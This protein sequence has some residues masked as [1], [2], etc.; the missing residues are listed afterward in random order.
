MRTLP[1]LTDMAYELNPDGSYTKTAYNS[2]YIMLRSWIDSFINE[3]SY[4]SYATIPKIVIPNEFIGKPSNPSLNIHTYYAIMSLFIQLEAEPKNSSGYT[5]RLQDMNFNKINSY[6]D[7]SKSLE[8]YNEETEEFFSRAEYWNVRGHLFDL[9][10]NVNKG[11]FLSRHER[12]VDDLC[13]FLDRENGKYI[14][15]TYTAIAPETDNEGNI[16]T[17]PVSKSQI[18]WDNYQPDTRDRTNTDL[19]WK[20][21]T[22]L[23]II[24]K[25]VQDLYY[26]LIKIVYDY[27]RLYESITPYMSQGE[28]YISAITKTSIDNSDKSLSEIHKEI[29]SSGAT[30]ELPN[31]SGFSRYSDMIP[32]TYNFFTKALER[33]DASKYKND[34]DN[35]VYLR[36]F[37]QHEV[38][39]SVDFFNE[40]VKMRDKV[41]EFRS[42]L[43]I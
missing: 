27:L 22:T 33:R 43:D 39:K 38:L 21:N 3:S 41:K 37:Y 42:R 24:R 15:A 36:K 4:P 32:I 8:D 23:E 7:S 40:A 5:E 25:D 34:D 10:T 29:Q 9:L 16:I 13:S 11:T 12:L 35:D 18:Y 20:I 14:S 1:C 2:A 6:A 28:T 31:Q 26:N 30:E 17:P 19:L